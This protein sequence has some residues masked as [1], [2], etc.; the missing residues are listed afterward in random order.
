MLLHGNQRPIRTAHQH[1]VGVH[2][3]AR[4]QRDLGGKNFIEHT[5]IGNAAARAGITPRAR[6]A[7]VR[8]A[9]AKHRFRRVHNVQMRTW[10]KTFKRRAMIP[11]FWR[12]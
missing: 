10:F 9:R 2:M 7:N 6:R 3:F 5:Q 4:K 8:M 12:H 1:R 11:I